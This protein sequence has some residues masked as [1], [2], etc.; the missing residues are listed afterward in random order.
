MATKSIKKSTDSLKLS[1]ALK[2]LKKLQDKH[3][4]VIESKDLA[5]SQRV[6]LLETGFIRSVMKGWYICSNPSDHDG[7]STAW[8]T[9][10]WAFMSGY[11]A[12]RFG[13]RYCLNAEAS[14][15]LH[16]GSTTV[17]KQITIVSKDGG[18]SIVKLPFDTSLVIYQDEK[19]VSKTR[20]E[21]RGLQV[22][23]EALCMVGPQFFINHPMEAEI[24]LAMVRD[25]AEL[26]ATLL[27]GNCLPTAAARLAGAL[28]FTNRKDDGERIIK[29]LNKAGHAIQAKN[30]FE[31]TEPTISQSRE[32]SPY[33]LRIRSMWAT[34]REDVIQNFPKAP[35]IP[36]SPAVYMKQIQ[37]RYVADAYNS[38]SIEGY[39]VTDELIERIAKE[40]WN[41]EI[42]EEDKK[43]KDTLAARGYFLAFNEVKESIKLILAR[44]NSGD[45]VRKSH[46]DWYAA[47][48]NPTVLAG[49]LQR[50]Q[51]AGYRTGPVFIRNS[52]H[53]PLPREALLD[54]MEALFD[55]IE[56]E[57]EACVRAVLGHHIFVF[58]HPYFDG[59][60]RIGRFLM[61]ALLASG[62][63]PWTVVR[64]SERKRYMNALE[65]AS[66]DGD[67]KPL[68]KFI[69]GEMAQ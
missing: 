15:L 67:I 34:W 18:T 52:L 21:I 53:T 22:I 43:S 58:I 31:L 12:K 59:N 38:L 50:H 2:T 47:M 54:S 19:R 45:V 36:K 44:S 55:L 28:T 5:D 63:Y 57:P 23:A 11:L 35:R 1:E 6:L 29:A 7:D 41:P 60:G 26:L 20:T 49:I 66:V 10:Y 68:T 27:M 33:V 64:V 14:L 13:K 62:G 42:S 4:G 61:N 30:P 69:A 32:K 51:L 40:G 16:T 24:G 8:Y 48:F 9:N 39:Q 17:P 3:H 25:P 46:H 37:E 65:K 56:N